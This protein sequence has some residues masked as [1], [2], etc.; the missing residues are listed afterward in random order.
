MGMT[1]GVDRS[2]IQLFTVTQC[3]VNV[4][5]CVLDIFASIC[6]LK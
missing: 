1:Q 6:T 3:A 2:K 4:H 5:D